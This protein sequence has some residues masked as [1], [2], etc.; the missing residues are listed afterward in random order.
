MLQIIEKQVTAVEKTASLMEGNFKR[1]ASLKNSLTNYKNIL[2]HIQLSIPDIP[3]EN[4]PSN[5]PP[6]M[7]EPQDVKDVLNYIYNPDQPRGDLSRDMQ[8][9]H[10]QTTTLAAL[11]AAELSIARADKNFTELADLANEID[12]T[13]SLKDS[14]DM[15]NKLLLKILMAVE[16]L[17]NLEAQ[18]LRMQAAKYYRGLK[19]KAKLTPKTRSAAEKLQLEITN[20]GKMFKETKCPTSMIEANLC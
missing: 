10:K 17:K 7:T 1:A 11:E 8:N 9:T 12:I 20:G 5:Q 19:R 4:L 15:S 3:P 18:L 6:N 13:T 16:E 2:R 14:S